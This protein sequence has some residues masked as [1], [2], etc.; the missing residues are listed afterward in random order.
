MKI[1]WTFCRTRLTRWACSRNRT[2]RF[3]AKLDGADLSTTVVTAVNDTNTR[4]NLIY[5]IFSISPT[6]ECREEDNKGTSS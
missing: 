2:I 4:P 5:Q 1:I 6:A 3:V